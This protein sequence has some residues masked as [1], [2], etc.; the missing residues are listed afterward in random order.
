MMKVFD[1]KTPYNRSQTHSVVAESMAKAEEIFLKEYPNTEISEI[2]LHSNYVQIQAA[3]AEKKM[4]NRIGRSHV[5]GTT[6][7]NRIVNVA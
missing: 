4:N 5:L 1:I 3:H 2:C 7:N 6:K